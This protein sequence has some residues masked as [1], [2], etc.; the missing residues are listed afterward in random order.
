MTKC[1][2]AEPSSGLV[3]L[4]TSTVWLLR[5]NASEVLSFGLFFGRL[6]VAIFG[7]TRT[8]HM[9]VREAM[10]GDGAGVVVGVVASVK[11]SCATLDILLVLSYAR[12]PK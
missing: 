4:G 2:G 6:P 1:F 8:G 9:C 7:Q 11:F 3:G 5:G 10:H 12:N